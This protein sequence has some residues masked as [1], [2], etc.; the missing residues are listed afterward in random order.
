MNYHS[1]GSD[2]MNINSFFKKCD[3]GI[4]EVW[5]IKEDGRERIDKVF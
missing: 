2:T 4:V 3:R 5:I 1:V